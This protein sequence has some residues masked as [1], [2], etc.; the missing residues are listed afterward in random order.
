M[1]KKDRTKIIGDIAVIIVSVIVAILLIKS[2]A[3][4][5]VLLKISDF[6]WIGV[7]VMGIF[8]ASLFTVA[9]ATV[10]LLE[11]T[12]Y[13]PF[14]LVAILGGLG[15]VIGDLIIFRFIKDHLFKDII[16]GLNEQGSQ[17]ILK[18]RS[19][20]ILKILFCIIGAIIVAVPLPDEIG[21]ALMGLSKIKTKNFIILSFLLNGLGI[22]AVCLL[23]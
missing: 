7:I 21:L 23:I 14:W 1:P 16:A 4:N 17:K 10:V 2:G 9:P 8:Y 20:K 11:M 3:V 13:Y 5:N 22:L 15:A 18:L 19:H 12:H 6:G